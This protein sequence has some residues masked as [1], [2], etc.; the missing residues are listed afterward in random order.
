LPPPLKAAA[1]F[2]VVYRPMVDEDLPFIADLFATTRA[3]EM[4]L[5]GWPET[6]QQA[7]LAQQHKAQHHHYRTFYPKAEWL[8]VER[9]RKPV[10]R[11]YLDR[12]EGAL[13]VIDISL[14]PTARGGGI[15]GAIMA[16]VIEAARSEGLDV[17]LHVERHNRAIG[18]YQRLGFEYVREEGLYFELRVKCG[19]VRPPFNN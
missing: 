8:I 2:G 12:S 5:T 10:G 16:D 3:E 1:R 14:L 15:G 13:F 9:A 6:M 19:K 7:F 18:L 11:L 4:A 17:V